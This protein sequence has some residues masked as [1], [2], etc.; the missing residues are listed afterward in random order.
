M[1][2]ETLQY[3]ELRPN[4]ANKRFFLTYRH[5][6]CINSPRGINT[7]GKMASKIAEYLRL[8]SPSDYTGHC[9]IVDL[10]SQKRHGEWKSSAVAEGYVENS[11]HGKKII[12]NTL[13]HPVASVSEVHR[14]EIVNV[15]RSVV[16]VP[17][18]AA[19]VRYF[20]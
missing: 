19:P 16:S 8:D 13:T 4:N 10:L 11:L 2:P 12:A 3:R 18:Q 7:F 15:T 17:T 9:C 1:F 20:V 5:G 14:S 6:Q